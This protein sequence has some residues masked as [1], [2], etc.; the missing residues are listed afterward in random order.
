M[1]LTLLLAQVL[2]RT[3]AFRLI[4]L[5]RPPDSI[6]LVSPA[7]WRSTNLSGSAVQEMTDLNKPNFHNLG[8]NSASCQPRI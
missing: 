7:D 4:H 3:R 5:G 1:D 8:P 2:F 6:P